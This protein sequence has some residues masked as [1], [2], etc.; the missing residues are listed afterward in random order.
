M[1]SVM[2][3]ACGHPH[4]YVINAKESTQR[5][6]AQ[7]FTVGVQQ[8]TSRL[9]KKESPFRP[10]RRSGTS[11]EAMKQGWMIRNRDT[12]GHTGVKIERERER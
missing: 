8:E 12:E 2:G 4:I 7:F 10:E 1:E 9:Y 6:T 5:K 3:H 11:G